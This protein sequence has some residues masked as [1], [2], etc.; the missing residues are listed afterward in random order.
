MNMFNIDA[1]FGWLS[2]NQAKIAFKK[3]SVP[4]GSIIINNNYQILSLAHNSNGRILGHAEMIAM[5]KALTKVKDLNGCTLYCTLEPCLMCFGAM[6]NL[7]LA[8]LVL[9]TW[10]PKDGCISY[11]GVNKPSNMIIDQGYYQEESSNLLKNFF[12]EK[13][14]R[15]P[16]F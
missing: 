11:Y 8:R 3:K 9:A 1:H 13:R 7:K 12:K 15:S 14:L 5:S 2:L 6:I 10:S 4:I 16:K